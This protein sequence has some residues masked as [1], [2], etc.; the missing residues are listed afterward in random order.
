MTKPS[1]L[2]NDREREIAARF[3]RVRFANQLSQPKF[4]EALGVTL[5]RVA[6]IEYGRTPLTVGLADKLSAQFD[7][8]LF[9]LANG[10]GRMCPCGG[11]ICNIAPEIDHETL[12]S[13]AFSKELDSKMVSD[14]WFATVDSIINA[15][16]EV[17]LPKGEE[18]NKYYEHLHQILD[19]AFIS[20]PHTAKEKLYV[21][22]FRTIAKFSHD[23]KSGEKKTPG[24]FT[25][26]SEKKS[27]TEVT[28]CAN[29]KS[30]KPQMPD[31]LKRLNKATS[32]RGAK[33]ALAKHLGLPL[34]SVSQ[35]LSG[36]REPGGE[37]TLRLLHWVEQQERQK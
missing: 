18:A 30:V 19:Q 16:D 27:L 21:L 12:F 34:V 29:N 11:L 36:E 26:H 9:W 33:T 24:R 23:W 1:G 14:S 5:G 28:G 7:V 37:N 3:R 32:E 35:W 6:S 17:V 4:A 13:L 25:L 20:L 2:V 15:S 10:E 22:V 31:F 8:S